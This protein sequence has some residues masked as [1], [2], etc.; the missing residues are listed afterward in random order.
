LRVCVCCG[1]LGFTYGS[2]VATLRKLALVVTHYPMCSARGGSASAHGRYCAHGSLLSGKRQ[3]KTHNAA[4]G[5]AAVDA[6]AGAASN[7]VA[8][9][10][11]HAEVV[12]D[13]EDGS[14]AAPLVVAYWYYT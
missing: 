12:G 5:V 2:E 4:V 6:A 9:R 3:M 1:L 8:E 13:A 14:A 11:V 7:F 10:A